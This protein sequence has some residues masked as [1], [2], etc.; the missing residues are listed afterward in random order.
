MSGKQ[1]IIYWDTSVLLAWIK[2]EPRP[3][4]EMD[5]VNDIA[6][7]IHKNNIILLTSVITDTEVLDSMLN[8]SEKQRLAD[9]FKHPNCQK[10]DVDPKISQLTSN[11][12]DY[13]QQQK[14]INNSPTLTVPDAIHLA[15][16]IHYEANAF[17]TFDEGKK[18]GLNLL[19]LNGNVAGNPLVVCKPP[20]PPQ[21]SLNLVINKDVQEVPE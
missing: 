8:D 2:D 11:I 13:Y 5:G 9:F 21:P 1:Q 10:V 6:D 16:A 19:S 20:I 17:H 12:R 3:N 7:K 14:L 18:G 4:H 15:T